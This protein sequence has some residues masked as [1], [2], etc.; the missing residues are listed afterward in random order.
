[1]VFALLFLWIG[2]TCVVG[3]PPVLT[4]LKAQSL[5]PAFTIVGGVLMIVGSVLLVL[6]R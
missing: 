4:A 2:L 1:M 3:V 6:G 5:I